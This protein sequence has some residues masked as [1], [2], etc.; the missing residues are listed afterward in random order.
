MFGGPH[1]A[2]QPCPCH[3]FCSVCWRTPTSVRQIPLLAGGMICLLIRSHEIHMFLYTLK[4]S[5][6]L[7][8]ASNPRVWLNPCFLAPEKTVPGLHQSQLS[9]RTARNCW[10]TSWIGPRCVPQCWAMSSSQ[11]GAVKT[12]LTRLEWCWRNYVLFGGIRFP[13]ISIS[14]YLLWTLIKIDHMHEIPWKKA[15]YYV[16]LGVNTFCDFNKTIDFR[17]VLKG[18]PMLAI[19]DCCSRSLLTPYESSP[20]W[21]M[22]FAAWGRHGGHRHLFEARM[23]QI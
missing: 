13:Y 19:Y 8:E 1:C 21:G 23:Q 7:P 5:V 18:Y 4:T 10:R 2:S 16:A 15:S 3:V 12:R 9:T 22:R 20:K 17:I 11:V 6:F 14:P